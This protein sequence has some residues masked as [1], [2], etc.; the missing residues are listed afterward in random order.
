MCSKYFSDFSFSPTPT[1]PGGKK[2]KGGGGGGGG[3]GEEFTNLLV[4]SLSL[5]LK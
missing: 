4:L 5:S 2:K 3:G 1:S